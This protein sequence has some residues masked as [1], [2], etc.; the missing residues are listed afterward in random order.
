MAR[1]KD[2]KKSNESELERRRKLCKWKRAYIL[3][4][5]L[6]SM[7]YSIYV[8]SSIFFFWHRDSCRHF[9]VYWLFFFIVKDTC[10]PCNGQTHASCQYSLNNNNA[11]LFYLAFSSVI[12]NI[13]FC[14]SSSSSCYLGNFI[15]LYKFYYLILMCLLD[16]YS[17]V[18]QY[19]D[20]VGELL[21]V[22]FCFFL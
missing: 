14:R 2:K 16:I 7:W 15:Y 12:I 9:V 21:S 1:L 3:Y 20:F 18:R 8:V 6:F 13:W 5:S 10:F 19:F 17:F 11:Y 4:S 22:M